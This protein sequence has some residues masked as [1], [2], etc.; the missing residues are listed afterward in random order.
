MRELMEALAAGQGERG[1]VLEV[2][3]AD[4]PRLTFRIQTDGPRIVLLVES[5]AD[6][7]TLERWLRSGGRARI[8]RAL[9][10]RR[11]VVVRPGCF[12]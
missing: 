10:R 11:P 12:T 5:A 4:L 8:E 2:L 9:D 3:A 7:Y 1:R 6:R